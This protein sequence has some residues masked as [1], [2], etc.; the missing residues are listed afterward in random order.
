MV[1]IVFKKGEETL[2]LAEAPVTVPL[3]A[4]AEKLTNLHNDRK[5]LERLVNGTLLF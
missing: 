3:S 1:Q 4:L 5:R 2:F